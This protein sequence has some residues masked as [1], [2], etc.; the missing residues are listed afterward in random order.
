MQYV[1]FDMNEWFSYHFSEYNN[2]TF[3]Q[4]SQFE[5]FFVP[6]SYLHLDSILLMNFENLYLD[7]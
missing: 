6:I 7:F 1:H 5:H 3:P 4:S 2:I